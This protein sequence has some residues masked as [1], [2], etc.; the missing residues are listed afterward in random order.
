MKALRASC[1]YHYYRACC[2]Y[3]EWN[4]S[5]K[6]VILHTHWNNLVHVYPWCVLNE[7]SRNLSGLKMVLYGFICNTVYIKSSLGHTRIYFWKKKGICKITE[8]P[9]ESDFNVTCIPPSAFI[10]QK[11]TIKNHLL[12]FQCIAS[13]EMFESCCLPQKGTTILTFKEHE[14]LIKAGLRLLSYS[15][16]LQDCVLSSNMK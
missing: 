5:W 7:A 9:W 3:V 4:F 10:I 14:S 12:Y 15:T 2:R 8:T 16:A 11:L 13:E 1:Y 6:V